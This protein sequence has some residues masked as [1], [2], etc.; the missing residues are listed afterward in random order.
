MC[1]EGKVR[2]RC[3]AGEGRGCARGRSVG[4]G[5]EAVGELLVRRRGYGR[6]REGKEKSLTWLEDGFS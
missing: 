3:G 5:C 4:H 2:L 1:S 6:K